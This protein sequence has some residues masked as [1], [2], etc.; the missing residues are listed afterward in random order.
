[1]VEDSRHS[2]QASGGN[3]EGGKFNPETWRTDFGLWWDADGKA[4]VERLLR[5]KSSYPDVV[6]EICQDV[7]HEL[8]RTFHRGSYEHRS[9]PELHGFVRHVVR[10]QIAQ[11]YDRKTK[12]YDPLMSFEEMPPQ[13][14]PQDEDI[15]VEAD[16]EELLRQAQYRAVLDRAMSKLNDRRRQVIRLYFWDDK[17]HTEIAHAL[18][19]SEAL[20]RQDK[21]RALATMRAALAEDQPT[22]G[23]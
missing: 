2:Q 23:L 1:M 9:D 19:I 11:F 12:K 10:A 4:F 6:E 8:T 14:D 18:N 22:L 15:N 21:R 13:F 16:F 20:V 3:R 7:A 17:T 5:Q